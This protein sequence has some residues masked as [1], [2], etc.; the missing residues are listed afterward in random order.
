MPNNVGPER[1]HQQSV[2][3]LLELA[4]R[5]E[6]ETKIVQHEGIRQYRFRKEYGIWLECIVSAYFF[7]VEED[8]PW[9]YVCGFRH[10]DAD[11][12]LYLSVVE[13]ILEDPTC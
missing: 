13:K 9:K 8:G 4:K 11:D 12:P 7:Q 10:E 1:R 3:K 6:W 5:Y 2:K